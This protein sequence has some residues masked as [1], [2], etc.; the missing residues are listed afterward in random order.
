MKR[1]SPRNSANQSRSHLLHKHMLDEHK[2]TLTDSEIHEICAVV[3][4][5]DIE[6]A[7]AAK[8]LTAS[9][10][11]PMPGGEPEVIRASTL[12]AM[13]PTGFTGTVMHGKGSNTWMGVFPPAN[14]RPKAKR[15]WVRLCKWSGVVG[16]MSVNSRW[17]P[18]SSWVQIAL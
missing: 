8:A 18:A 14:A 9:L 3:R 10:P 7:A 15:Q 1:R 4:R 11:I 16:D 17:V 13:F 6:Q 2:L 12:M 5:M